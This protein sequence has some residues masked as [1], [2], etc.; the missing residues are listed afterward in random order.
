M[1][2]SNPAN[3]KVYVF[4][5]DVPAVT[6]GEPTGVTRQAASLSGTVDP[7]G[8]AVSECK[9]EYGV[10]NELGNGPYDHSVPCKQTPGEIGAGSGPVAVSAQLEGLEAGEL[11]H[12]RLVVTNA[13]GAGQASGLLATQG[14]GFGIK[15]YE[16]S[17][18][19]EDGTPDTQAGS[20]PYKFVNSFTLNSHF[21]RQESNAD[22]PYI[23][24]PDG[25]LRNLK[26]DLPPGF[27][28]DPNA[29]SQKCTGQ[30]LQLY[31]ATGDC[32][33]ESLVGKL[34]LY[35]SENSVRQPKLESPLLAMAPVRGVALRL[36]T[37][38]FIPAA[39][40]QQRRCRG[41]QLPRAGD[42]DGSADVGAR[43]Q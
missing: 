34:H 18:L 4:G 26:I 13:N 11:Y 5:S 31:F 39:V 36:G 9:F 29:T 16:I 33:P 41:R 7:R 25:V 15:S 37:N 6:A 20:H 3:G 38:F 8:V 42:G 24:L 30:Q 1:Y 28:G 27:V 19:N 32:P 10:T 12:F 14:V 21:K 23:R 17:F 35:W 43:H 22:S 40:Y 2:V